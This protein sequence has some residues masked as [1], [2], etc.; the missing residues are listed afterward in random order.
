MRVA[1]KTRSRMGLV[2]AAVAS[3]YDHKKGVPVAEKDGRYSSEQG[4]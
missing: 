3:D 1:W 4:R 2:S